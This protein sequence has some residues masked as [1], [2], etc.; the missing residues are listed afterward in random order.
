MGWEKVKERCGRKEK[1]QDGLSDKDGH[2]FT[3][4]CCAISGSGNQEDDPSS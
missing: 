1:G 2:V 4:Q 3:V